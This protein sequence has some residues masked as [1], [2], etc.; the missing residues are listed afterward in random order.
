MLSSELFYNYRKS[1]KNE[2]AVFAE[3]DG[4]SYL[5]APLRQGYAHLI[6]QRLPLRYF[7]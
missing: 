5:V 4:T 1:F 7:A 2:D 6:H 3:F